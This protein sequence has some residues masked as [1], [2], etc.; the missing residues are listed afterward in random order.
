MTDYARKLLDILQEENK[1]RKEMP[2]NLNPFETIAY[3]KE[4]NQRSLD[5][6][7]LLM[8]QIITTSS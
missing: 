4:T 2:K 3:L 7:L 1:R 6:S 5:K 8:E